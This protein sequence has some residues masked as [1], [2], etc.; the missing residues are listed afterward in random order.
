MDARYGLD[1]LNAAAEPAA[2][3]DGIRNTLLSRIA[4]R[5]MYQASR[6]SREPLQSIV[7]VTRQDGA[8]T[9]RVKAFAT[10]K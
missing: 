1:A 7:V 9:M 2:F 10:I 8:H 4:E 3:W 5:E 6:H